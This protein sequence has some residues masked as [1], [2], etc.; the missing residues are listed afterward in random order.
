MRIHYLI[1][2]VF[3]RILLQLHL[4]A[5]L[6]APP[7]FNLGEFPALPTSTLPRFTPCPH[8]PCHLSLQIYPKA[9]EWLLMGRPAGSACMHK[10]AL[11]C[12][13]SP[14]PPCSDWKQFL[15]KIYLVAEEV[16][17]TPPE[18]MDTA[19]GPVEDLERD[20]ARYTCVCVCQ[21]TY[22]LEDCLEYL[23]A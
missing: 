17:E 14:F 4:N 2:T 22:C 3:C 7:N 11:P 18:P 9:T 20:Q 1:R 6:F 15:M 12:L 13:T 10:L 16:N 8:Q 19:P 21:S 23:L 5:N